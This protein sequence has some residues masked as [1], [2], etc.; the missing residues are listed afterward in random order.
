MRGF[1]CPDAIRAG[2]GVD[3]VAEMDDLGG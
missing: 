2:E 3:F 1:L